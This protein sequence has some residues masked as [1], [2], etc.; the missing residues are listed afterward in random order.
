[1]SCAVRLFGVVCVR[2][3]SVRLLL[4][5]KIIIKKSLRAGNRQLQWQQL[6]SSL[7]VSQ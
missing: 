5:A 3:A 2:V 1:M 6:P 4:D 7:P